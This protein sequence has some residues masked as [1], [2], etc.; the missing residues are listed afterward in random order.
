VQKLNHFNF[1]VESFFCK[2]ALE[3]TKRKKHTDCYYFSIGQINVLRKLVIVYAT[4]NGNNVIDKTD[5]TKVLLG[6]QDIH[7]SYDESE[8]IPENFE[9]YCKFAI[10]SGYLNYYPDLTSLLYRSK[11]MYVD[12]AKD[13]PYKNETSFEIF[14]NEAV[15]ISPLESIFLCSALFNPFL[16]DVTLIRDQTV[17]LPNDYFKQT[18]IDN[19]IINSLIDKLSI[20]VDLAKEHILEEVTNKNLKEIPLG[21]NLDLFRKSPML[22]LYDGR[23]V[24]LSFVSLL[25]KTTKNLPWM[26][27]LGENKC[28][29]N[30]TR[31]RGLIFDRYIQWLCSEMSLLNKNLHSVYIPAKDTKRHEEI[32]DSIL[33]QDDKIVIIEAK[34]R[35]F[36]E[37]FKATGDWGLDS[38]FI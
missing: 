7:N 35:Q 33:I 30:L 3:R 17:I 27:N 26:L 19:K 18:N 29:N 34:S 20:S 2:S 11:K 24:C 4:D 25:E 6:A 15:G 37:E 32:G 10:R 38:R 16:Q 21:Y 5:L 9:N 13:E 22:K 23:L 8:A 31:Y 36:K 12:I 14:F 28:V 1:L